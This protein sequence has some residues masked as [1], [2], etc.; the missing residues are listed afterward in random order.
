LQ[1]TQIFVM[2]GQT[3]ATARLSCLA[4]ELLDEKPGS[5]GKGIPGVRLRVMNANER[6]VLPGEVGEIVADGPNVSPGYWR[7]PDESAVSFRNGKLY[8]GD[9]ATLD[10]DGFIY[11][12]DRAKDFVKC[13][14]RRVSCRELEEQLLEFGHLIEAAVI[15][16]P[17]DILGEAIK[18]F[19]VPRDGYSTALDES[20]R[21]FCRERMLPQFNPKTIVVLD[22]VPKNA[23]GKVLKS[24]LRTL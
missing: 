11:L 13:G 17:D 9:L 22:A 12:V 4:P 8:T 7:D 24:S 23:S 14:G 5:I 2:Y 15:G 20:L 16:V 18:A 10:E 6:D 21:K 1:G 19:V 3:E